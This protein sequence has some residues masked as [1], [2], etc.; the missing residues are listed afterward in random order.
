MQIRSLVHRSNG[1]GFFLGGEGEVVWRTV[2]RM[3]EGRGWEKQ[4]ESKGE[5]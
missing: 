1:R 5:G 2:W 4:G 3:R